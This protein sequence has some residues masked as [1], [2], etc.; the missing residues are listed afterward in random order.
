MN[1]IRYAQVGTVQM[2][3][4]RR[5]TNTTVGVD[6]FHFCVE[7][8]RGLLNTPMVR[9]FGTDK[10]YALECYN[11]AVDHAKSIEEQFS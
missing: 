11:R 2:R 10:D 4:V 7:G 8:G 3:L 9:F 5:P 1:I 6:N